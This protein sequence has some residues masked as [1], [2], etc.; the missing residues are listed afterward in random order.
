MRTYGVIDVY[1]H[2]FLTSGV[3][4]GDWSA[5]LPGRFIPGEITPD[6]D[7]TGGWMDLRSDLHAMRR[8]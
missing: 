4:G 6:T 8:E 1:L 7:W 2:A 5:L 3:E